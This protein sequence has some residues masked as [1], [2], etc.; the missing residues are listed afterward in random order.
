MTELLYSTSEVARLFNINRVTIYRWIKKGKIKAYKIG[1]HHKISVSE[2][3]RL[4]RKFGF[5]ASAIDDLCGN[6]DDR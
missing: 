1:K 4:L 6:A 3:V 5:S 2:V